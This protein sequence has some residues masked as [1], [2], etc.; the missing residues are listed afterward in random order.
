MI[1]K[2]VCISG[3]F[4]KKIKAPIGDENPALRQYSF[5]SSFIKKIKAPI[6]DENNWHKIIFIHNFL[7]Y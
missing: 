4:I 5:S 3:P 6:G 2:S 1:E 7:L